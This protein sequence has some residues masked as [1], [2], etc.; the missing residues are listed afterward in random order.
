MRMRVGE[1]QDQEFRHCR[2]CSPISPTVGNS[3]CTPIRSSLVCQ[4]VSGVVGRVSGR[5][6]RLIAKLAVWLAS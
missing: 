2:R 5:Q 6:L 1:L 3:A 4:Q